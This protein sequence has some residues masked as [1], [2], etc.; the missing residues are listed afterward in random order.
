MVILG[1]ARFRLQRTRPI[2]RRSPMH[3]GESQTG[4]LP[5]TLGRE[6]RLEEMR[7]HL[8]RHAASLVGQAM[9]T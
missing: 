4:S 1:L 6:E 7:F 3:G 8:R 5:N 9:Q 2:V